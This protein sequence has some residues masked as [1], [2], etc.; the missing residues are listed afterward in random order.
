MTTGTELMMQCAPTIGEVIEAEKRQ[1]RY[2]AIGWCHA[3]CC[4]ALDDGLDPRT[5]EVPAILEKAKA[6]L[7]P[8]NVKLT[9]VPP[10]DAK[11]GD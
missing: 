10:T 8:P 2:E 4:A 9:G 3:F 5:I 11:E 6:Q 1:A 7:E